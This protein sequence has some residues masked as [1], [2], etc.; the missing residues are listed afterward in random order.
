MSGSSKALQFLLQ[1]RIAALVCYGVPI[2]VE[3]GQFMKSTAVLFFK[4]AYKFIA[5]DLK[6][7]SFH[8]WS[9]FSGIMW[10]SYLTVVETIQ[11][12]IFIFLS[13]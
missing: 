6:H 3:G 11:S 10:S 4:T 2:L 9:M 12:I 7:C 5:G 1:Q 8:F 13:V